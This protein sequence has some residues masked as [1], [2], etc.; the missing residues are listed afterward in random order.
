MSESLDTKEAERKAFV[1]YFQDGLWDIGIGGV[2]LMFV[3]APFLS[4]S[5]GDFWSSAVFVP[6]WGVLFIVLWILRR[7]VVRPRPE[8]AGGWGP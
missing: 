1:S 4:A 7:R 8:P 2:L 5:L 6:F 3:I